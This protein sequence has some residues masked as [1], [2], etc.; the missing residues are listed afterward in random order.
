VSRASRPHRALDDAHAEAMAR[1]GGGGSMPATGSLVRSRDR[2]K[3][4][5]TMQGPRTPRVLFARLTECVSAR[6]T[7]YLRGWAGA[8]NLVAFRAAD[9]E[10]GRATWEL[11]LVEREPRDGGGQHAT[12][13]APAR[14][15]P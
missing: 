9:D 10:Q 3:D 14:T 7:R 11:F 13:T 6:G 4:I 8:S 1:D 15:A 2:L 5:R 12:A